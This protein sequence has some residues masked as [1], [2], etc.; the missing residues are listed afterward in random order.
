MIGIPTKQ[1]HQDVTLKGFFPSFFRNQG[2]NAV[3]GDHSITTPSTTSVVK[4]FCG[5]FSH[6]NDP[7]VLLKFCSPLTFNS[8][9]APACLQTGS[10]EI[11]DYMG[12]PS[13]CRVLG[14]GYTT[15]SGEEVVHCFYSKWSNKKHLVIHISTLL[16][17]FSI[18]PTSSFLWLLPYHTLGP[19][20][21]HLSRLSRYVA[22]YIIPI[23]IIIKVLQGR[24]SWKK[25]AVTCSTW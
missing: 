17:S 20:L 16:F 23:T 11:T 12:P 14:W 2:V 10:A 6:P 25:I 19:L 7:I 9:V 8:Q 5:V 15:A 13:K 18:S 3:F 4:T 1:N 24:W 22:R 21:Y